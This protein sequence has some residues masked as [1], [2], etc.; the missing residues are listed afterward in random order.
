MNPCHEHNIVRIRRRVTRSRYLNKAVYKYHR[1][2]ITIPAKYKDLAEAFMNKDLT[3]E[4]RQE[5][6]TLIIV[7][8]PV[9][10]FGS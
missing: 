5:D 1:Y 4:A 2:E 7:A 10:R 3:V 9:G 8:R 6:S